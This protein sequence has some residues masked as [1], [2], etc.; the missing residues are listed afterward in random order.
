MTEPRLEGRRGDPAT[1]FSQWLGW[2]SGGDWAM[3]FAALLAIG[4]VGGIIFYA[5][6]HPSTAQL[7]GDVTTGQGIPGPVTPAPP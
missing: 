1:T 6:G 4:L 2:I 5:V 3:A 7:P